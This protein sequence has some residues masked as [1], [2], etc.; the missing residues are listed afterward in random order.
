[1]SESSLIFSRCKRCG[2]SIKNAKAQ[3]IGYGATCYKKHQAEAEQ[4][5]KTG[6][7]LGEGGQSSL[8][9]FMS[10]TDHRRTSESKRAGKFTY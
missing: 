2:R 9:H 10:F 5:L 7:E 1:M 4:K 8:T 3:A 6:Q